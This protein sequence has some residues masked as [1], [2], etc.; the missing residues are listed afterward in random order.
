MRKGITFFTLVACLIAGATT[1]LAQ[2][3]A[4]PK[5][6][7]GAETENFWSRIDHQSATGIHTN[8]SQSALPVNP[9]PAVITINGGANGGNVPRQIVAYVNPNFGG[10]VAATIFYPLNRGHQDSAVWQLAACPNCTAPFEIE[11]FHGDIAWGSQSGQYKI[12]LYTSSANGLGQEQATY[13]VW[14]STPPPFTLTG[15]DDSITISS[16]GNGG[17][18]VLFTGKIRGVKNPAGATYRAVVGGWAYV[19]NVMVGSDG[20]FSFLLPP[21]AYVSGP[22]VTVTLCR[23]TGECR[24]STTDANPILYAGGGGKG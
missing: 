2:R 3:P 9:A 6:V 14:D 22:M 8:A 24:T 7:F 16:P 19:D 12:I 21:G 23:G 11:L 10:M 20:S 17:P 1:T 4:P 18:Q 15:V 13:N 5:Q